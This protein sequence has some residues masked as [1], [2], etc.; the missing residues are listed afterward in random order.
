MLDGS[1]YAG[2]AEPCDDPG[3][4]F[5]RPRRPSTGL[6]EPCVDP[7]GEGGRRRNASASVIYDALDGRNVFLL[8]LFL[9][10]IEF[11]SA[12]CTAAL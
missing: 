8:L 1:E 10:W 5:R 3:M 12:H 2:L 11:L 4:T 6:K 7:A 9:C